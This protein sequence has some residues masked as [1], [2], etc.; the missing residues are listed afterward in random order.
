LIK[1][2]ENLVSL[3]S[4]L[5]ESLEFL[6]AFIKN[7]ENELAVGNLLA[8]AYHLT[9]LAAKEKP[10]L[11]KNGRIFDQI[12][13]AVKTFTD[14]VEFGHPAYER[15]RPVVFELVRILN[16]YCSSKY[17]FDFQGLQ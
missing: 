1:K 9:R 12:T 14:H 8:L 13:Q 7:A 5:G 4:I 17:Y 2:T 3:E 11:M 10:F 15:S 6:S 16:D